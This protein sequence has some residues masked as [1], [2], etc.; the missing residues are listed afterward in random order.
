MPKSTVAADCKKKRTPPVARNWLMGAAPSS[1][2][3]TTT[4]RI[5]PRIATPTMQITAAS[6]MGT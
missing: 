5:T 3:I 6:P 4:C 1:G 2:A